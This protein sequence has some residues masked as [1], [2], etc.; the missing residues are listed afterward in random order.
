MQ[1]VWELVWAVLFVRCRETRGL[2][3]TQSQ[4]C[5]LIT[6]QHVPARPGRRCC[7]RHIPTISL[8][9]VPEVSGGEPLAV[10]G[11]SCL[12]VAL[13]SPHWQVQGQQFAE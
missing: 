7:S 5:E 4:F 3:P 11:G 1:L 6:S 2:A 10:G 13:S 8:L 9:T 12:Q